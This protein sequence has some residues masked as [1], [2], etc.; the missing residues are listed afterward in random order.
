MIDKFLYGIGAIVGHFFR[1]FSIYIAFGIV[2]W[3]TYI[4]LGESDVQ[5]YLLVM[6]IVMTLIF[7]QVDN[8]S[9][10]I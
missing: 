4:H 10:R 1:Y 3:I 9:E 5:D 6:V 8:I 7:V 2:T